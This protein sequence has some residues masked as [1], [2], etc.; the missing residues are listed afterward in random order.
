MP[1]VYFAKDNMCTTKKLEMK[2]I[3]DYFTANGWGI[4]T[5]MGQAD[6]VFCPT[7]VGWKIKEEKSL[8]RLRE[9]NN[10]GKRVV[11]FG[12]L[13]NFNPAAVAEV[14]KGICIPAQKIEDTALLIENP[15]VAFSDIAEPSTFKSKEDYRL[16]DLTKRYVNIVDGCS[17]MCIYCPHRIGLGRIKSR[18]QDQILAQIRELVADGAKTI[19]LTGME[20][21]LYGMDTGTPYPVLL[22][23]VLEID[24]FFEIHVAQFNPYGV[25]RYYDDLLP[26]F[27]NSRITDIQI[28]IQTA[29]ER[30]LKLMRRP[31]GIREVG[32]F[33]K[34]VRDKNK[35]AV[36]RTDL[37]IGFPT[38]TEEELKESL[39]FTVDVFDE[40]AAYAIEIRGGLPIEK[41]KEQA[42]ST[43]EIKRRIDFAVKFIEDH[44]KMAHKGQQ[45]E[46]LSLIDLEARKET[47]R[48]AKRGL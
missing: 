48:K 43:E 30:I 5:D 32:S 28:P 17:F 18:S 11:S 36:L 7:C 8:E 10:S 37:I 3:C 24:A 12:C 2:K 15:K 42:Y 25:G 6:T 29:S 1:K 23:K 31:L 4:T 41:F 26:L 34:S 14:H 27:S 19:V 35:T 16:Y 20:T 13:N 39:K 22:K 38:E 9:A 40:V 45:G 44:G 46:D 47:L 33:L 21:A